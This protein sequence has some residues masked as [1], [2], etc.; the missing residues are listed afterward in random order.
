MEKAARH[1]NFLIQITFCTGKYSLRTKMKRIWG[2]YGREKGKSLELWRLG[3]FT[4]LKE[5]WVRRLVKCKVKTLG[6]E[7]DTH[8]I[9]L[10][11]ILTVLYG[12]EVQ[13]GNLIGSSNYRSLGK[14]KENIG[15]EESHKCWGKG[16]SF[17]DMINS[18]A[19]N[20]DEEKSGKCNY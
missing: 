8:W 6:K 15:L 13:Q 4:A 9:P 7:L 5:V 3:T 10:K 12:P 2:N 20:L 16:S 1:I 11:C 17:G 19:I 18:I 14:K